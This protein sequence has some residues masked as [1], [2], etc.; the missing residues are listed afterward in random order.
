[1]RVSSPHVSKGSIQ[2]E[3]NAEVE[4]SA[5]TPV[6]TP[7]RRTETTMR[8]AGGTGDADKS[9]RV[10]AKARVPARTVGLLTRTEESFHGVDGAV[11]VFERGRVGDA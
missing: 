3:V 10:P 2:V 9:V 1:V 11:E 5:D 8:V 4:W 7:L 6:R